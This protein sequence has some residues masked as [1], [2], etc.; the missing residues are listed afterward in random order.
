MWYMK[1]VYK[2]HDYFFKHSFSKNVSFQAENYNWNHLNNVLKNDVA[3]EL[4]SSVSYPHLDTLSGIIC[5]VFV[6]VRK[7]FLN[8]FLNC[9]QH[10]DCT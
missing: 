4:P 2:L 5:F 7:G 10:L 9:M 3:M 6:T 1:K 8:L